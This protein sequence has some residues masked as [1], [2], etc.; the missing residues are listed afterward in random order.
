[1][2]IYF[3]DSSGTP[4]LTSWW[5]TPMPQSITNGVSFT[6]TRLAGLEGPTPTR[7]PP[8][9]PRNTIF[10]RGFACACANTVGAASAAALPSASFSAMRRSIIRLSPAIFLSVGVSLAAA[11]HAV[12]RRQADNDP[13][14]P[15]DITQ[16]TKPRPPPPA[17][18]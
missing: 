14:P 16:P 18:H 11:Q 17:S 5:L 10:V 12:E 7:G 8:L 6:I 9:V 1:M 15:P 3:T 2:K 13:P 4:V